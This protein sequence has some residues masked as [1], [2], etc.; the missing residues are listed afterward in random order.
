MDKIAVI[1]AGGSGKRMGSEIPKQFLLLAGQPVLMRTIKTF[2]DY[3]PELTIITVLPA[4]QVRYW[5]MLCHNHRFKIPHKIVSGGTT[6]HNSVK[7]AMAG[8][9][10][11]AIV[12]VHDGVRPLVSMALIQTCFDTAAILGNAIPVIDIPESIRSVDG[13][14]SKSADRSAFRLVQTPQVFRSELLI[15]A[16]RQ[17]YDP[18][19]TDEANLVEADGNHIYLVKGQPSNIKLTTMLDIHIATAILESGND[20]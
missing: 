2:H 16:F 10:P 20:E 8:I 9:K 3:D 11:G 12:A 18:S 5:E 14:K 17:P 7:N 15:R 6:R 1:V 13:E 4:D 19:F